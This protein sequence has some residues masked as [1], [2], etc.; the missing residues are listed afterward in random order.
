MV[1]SCLFCSDR[2]GPKRSHTLRYVLRNRTT[3]DTYLVVVFSLF[4]KEDVNEDGSLKPAALE[5]AHEDKEMAKEA[6]KIPAEDHA[7]ENTKKGAKSAPSG[8]TDDD[9]VD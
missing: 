7:A 5:A 3:G 4:L 6:G 2:S 9:G 8:D 1:I